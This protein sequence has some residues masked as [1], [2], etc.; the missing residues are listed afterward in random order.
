M[1]GELLKLTASE[2]L[3]RVQINL[4]ET[5]CTR[6]VR[7]ASEESHGRRVYYVLLYLFYI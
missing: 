6:D 3:S 7:I 4:S 1:F 5:L 2:T